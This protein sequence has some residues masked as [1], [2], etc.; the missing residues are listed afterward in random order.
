VGDRVQILDDQPVLSMVV[1]TLTWIHA[2]H[3]EQAP[4]RRYASENTTEYALADIRRAL[5]KDRANEG[6]GID[7]HDHAK[8][9]RNPLISAVTRSAD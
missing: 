4:F 9:E 7:C 5:A 2:E 3:L 8:P 6:L 1:T